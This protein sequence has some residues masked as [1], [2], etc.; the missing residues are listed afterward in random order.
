[1]NLHACLMTQNELSDL[2]PNIAALRPHVDT[3]TIVDGGSIDGTIPYFRNVSRQ[4]PGVRFFIHPWKDNF[5]AQRNN[6]LRRVGEIATDGD[7]LVAFDPDEYLDPD[8]LSRLREVA[9]F[10]WENQRCALVGFRCRSV[11][12]RGTERVWQS[13]DNFWKRLLI[14]WN[15]DLQYTH[16]GEGAVHESLLG[17]GPA[18]YDT[19]HHPE[20]PTLFYEHRK[21]ENVI[22]PRG[23]RNYFCGGGGPNLGASNPRWVE[24]RAIADRLGLHAWHAMQ[25]YLLGG[26]IDSALRD[27]ILRYRHETGWD[28]SSEQREWYKTYFRLYHPEEEPDE[29]R[30]E[31]IE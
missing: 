17:A 11:S 16:M 18:S 27:W 7:W 28:G 13:E 31:S 10:A 12:L 25:A 6:Y 23:V 26:Q 24:L 14:R 19:G 21:Q 2:A 4:D 30:G 22:W 15:P 3:V 20:F 8:A 5:P 29:M 9:A 1:M